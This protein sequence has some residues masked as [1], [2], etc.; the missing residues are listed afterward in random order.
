MTSA[1]RLCRLFCL[2][3]ILA[4]CTQFPELDRTQ[5]PELKAAPYPDLIPLEPLLARARMPGA[6]PARTEASL[7]SRLAGLRARADRMRGTVLT[8]AEKR[9]LQTG[10]R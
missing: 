4:A 2:P 5:T 9:R 7:D 1:A 3:L 8:P 6:D 10:L